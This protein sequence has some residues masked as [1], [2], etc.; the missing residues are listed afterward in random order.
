[1]VKRVGGSRM[2]AVIFAGGFGTRLAEETGVRP[3]P[4]VDIGGMP[5]LYHIM[6]IYSAHGVN[7]FIVLVGYKGHMI[8]EYFLNFMAHVQD[9][10]INLR[11]GGISY[12]DGHRS[13]PDWHITVIDTGENTMTGGR[14]KRVQKLLEGESHF[15]VTYGDGVSEINIS[16]LESFHKSHGLVATV[17]AVKP[18][19]R[20]GALSIEQGTNTVTQFVEKPT[21]DGFYINGGF[22]ILTPQIFDYLTDDSCVFEQ[23][24]LQNLASDSQLKA[25]VHDGFW[26]CMDTLRDK[27]YLESLYQS[28][29]APWVKG[30]VS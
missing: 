27:Q 21:G 2:K 5:M 30:K 22:F 23:E 13:R 7:D 8:K 25:Y 16:A 20:F 15:A 3:K 4:L 29:N 10:S 1:M 19:G 9:I 11:T 17:T 28:G 24:P 26:Q 6:Q 18:P 14:L 12:V